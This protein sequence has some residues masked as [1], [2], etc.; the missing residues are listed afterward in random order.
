M[1]VPQTSERGGVGISFSQDGNFHGDNR[2]GGVSEAIRQNGTVQTDWG[3][4]V[5]F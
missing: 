2:L 5:A 1:T 3:G 4:T